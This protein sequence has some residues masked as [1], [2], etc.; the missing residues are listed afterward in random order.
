[1]YRFQ[2]NK[3]G[4]QCERA[5]NLVSEANGKKLNFELKNCYNLQKIQHKIYIKKNKAYDNY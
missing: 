5:K 4:E 2:K 3:P 1:M